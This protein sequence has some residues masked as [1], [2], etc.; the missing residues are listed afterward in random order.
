MVS[1][2]TL[3]A[4]TGPKVVLVHSS[5]AGAR[6]WRRLMR[7]LEDRFHVIAV[8]LFGYGQTPAWTDERSQ[9]LCDQA[10]LVEAA[11]PE[12]EDR[13]CLVGHSFGGSVAMMVA[14]RLGQRVAKLVLLEPNP[15][16]LL[17]QHQRMAAFAESVEL[18][19]WI[20]HHGS[21]GDWTTA[22]VR[23]ADYW[24]GT[25]T[26]SAMSDERRAAFIEGLKPNFYEWDAVMDE[27]TPLDLWEAELPRQTM[28]V[29]FLDTVRPIL[30]IVDLLRNDCPSWRFVAL[31]EGGHMA[32]LTCPD[33]VNPLIARYLAD[34]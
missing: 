12:T 18:R 5:V 20:K 15:F 21:S 29:S 10:S 33:L 2:D 3:E 32:P 24:G 26:W 7:D 4:G 34:G 22:A 14:R 9:T 30:E 13:V 8:N 16:F 28:V 31:P 27:T 11:I 6:Q 19:D 1:V 25:G 17:N 23:F